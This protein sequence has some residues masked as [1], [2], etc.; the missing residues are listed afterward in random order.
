MLPNPPQLPPP[1]ASA[2]T[3]ERKAAPARQGGFC[4]EHLRDKRGARGPRWARG[5]PVAAACA[6]AP[7]PDRFQAPRGPNQFPLVP[8]HTLSYRPRPATC[9]CPRSAPL[10]ITVFPQV[11]SRV[12]FA[13]RLNSNNLL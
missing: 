10:P 3:R 11:R 6:V 13:P 4:G 8:K 5:T 7:Y 1:P 9:A 12:P 2:Q